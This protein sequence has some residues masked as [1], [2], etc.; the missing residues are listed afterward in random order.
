MS[1]G[2][3][4]LPLSVAITTKNYNTEGTPQLQIITFFRDQQF[5]YAQHSRSKYKLQLFF[6]DL[7]EDKSPFVGLLILMFWTSGDVS[8]RFHSQSGYPY[9][10][11][12]EAYVIYVPSLLSQISGISQ[13]FALKRNLVISLVLLCNN[14]P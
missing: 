1:N 5:F 6:L 12:L 2:D 14:K 3:R 13:M 11:L 8:S 9:S 10:H 7:L 4:K